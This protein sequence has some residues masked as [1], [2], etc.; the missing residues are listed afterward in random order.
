MKKILL[1]VLCRAVILDGACSKYTNSKD[2]TS[3]SFLL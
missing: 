1:S 2:S 3:N